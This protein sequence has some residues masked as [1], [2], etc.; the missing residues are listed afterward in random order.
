MSVVALN[1]SDGLNRLN[2]EWSIENFSRRINETTQQ[3]A[4]VASTFV[5]ENTERL[6]TLR[7][8]AETAISESID[9]AKTKIS[10]Y[11]EERN[12]R[13]EDERKIYEKQAQKQQTRFQNRGLVQTG[14]G[15]LDN[16]ILVADEATNKISESVTKTV[17]SNLKI[18]IGMLVLLGAAL[19]AKDASKQK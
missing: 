16:A 2:D 8:R 3:L 18:F 9:T 4:T 13:K 6:N 15:F 19:L 5:Q 12:K 17:D 10:T 14:L 7:Q 11:V 1:G